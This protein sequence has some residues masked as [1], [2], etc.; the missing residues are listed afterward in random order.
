MKLLDRMVN[1]R[2][3]IPVIGQSG[4]SVH[5]TKDGAYLK[6]SDGVITWS[7]SGNCVTGKGIFV[8]ACARS[9]TL[10][11]AKILT[12]LGY[13][14]GHEITGPDGSVGYHLVIVKP[15]NC[16]HQV[17][18]P[19]DQ[20]SSASTLST[21]GIVEKIM[22]INPYTLLGRMQYWLVWNEMCEE[23]CIWRYRLEDLPNVWPEFLKR[24]GHKEVPIPDISTTTNSNKS[25]ARYEKV[26]WADLFGEN[27]ILAQKIK[28][29][30]IEYG[31]TFPEMGQNETN[32]SQVACA[33]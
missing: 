8:A 25:F 18:H 21:W 17:R 13:N 6:N 23:F 5:I 3:P 29:K 4:G 26:T 27:R 31:Y 2:I 24:I 20:I 22:D 19:I 30:A 16:F 1:G 33:V 9:G 15:K 7:Y 14:I 12:G 11:T 32:E 28:D 10:Y